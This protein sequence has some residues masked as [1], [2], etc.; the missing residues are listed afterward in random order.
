MNS[1]HG[2]LESLAEERKFRSWHLKEKQEPNKKRRKGRALQYEVTDKRKISTAAKFRDTLGY[3]QS[4]LWSEDQYNETV[5]QKET[6]KPRS[7]CVVY[8]VKVF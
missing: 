5:C 8:Q 4:S 6:P 2:I 3:A 1:E 7:E